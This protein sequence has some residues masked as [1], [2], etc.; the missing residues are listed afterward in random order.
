MP[1][2]RR[3]AAAVC[4]ISTILLLHAVARAT[5][6]LSPATDQLLARQLEDVERATEVYRDVSAARRAGYAR[7]R[8][9]MDAP[10]MGEHWVNRTLLAGEVDL[11]RPAVLQYIVVGER[12][13]LVGVTYGH[14]QRPGAPMPEGFA[15]D[16]DRWHAHDIESL[17]RRFTERES[18]LV[19]WVVDRSLARGQ[20]RGSGGRTELAM[21]HVWLWSANPD[22]IF[23]N[24]NPTLP[25]LRA[26]LPSA[27]ARAG[28]HAAARGIELLRP[29]SCRE[30]V[31]R[32][33]WVVKAD[34]GQRRTLEAACG[35][36]AGDLASARQRGLAGDSLNS[37]AA[38]S[39]HTL[40]RYAFGALGPEQLRAAA[41]LGR[42]AAGGEGHGP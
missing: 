38:E 7:P 2:P 30:A 24:Y 12:R 22:G 32:F 1:S 34:D 27:W 31:R 4:S 14:W 15:G 35:R 21:L 42:I 19:R 8:F 29:E 20:W 33:S 36:A 6:Q 11:A 28:D 40:A 10:L 37:A 23:A 13:L 3:P 39:W 25:Y 26:G 9:G 41:R 16:A 17:V 5:A 18:G